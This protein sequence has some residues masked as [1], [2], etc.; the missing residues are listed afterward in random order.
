MLDGST[1]TATVE[2]HS[3]LDE[4]FTI[5]T[6]SATCAG[7]LLNLGQAAPPVSLLRL[8]VRGLYGP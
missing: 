5:V 1:C 2:E 6:A 3:K 8:R 4:S 7:A